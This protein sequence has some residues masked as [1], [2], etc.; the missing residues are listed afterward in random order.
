MNDAKRKAHRKAAKTDEVPDD[1]VATPE[2]G[3]SQQNLWTQFQDRFPNLAAEMEESGP[4][5]RI[6]GVRWQETARAETAV[7]QPAKFAKY[8][9]D[10]VDFLRRC[11]TEEE[12]L[13]IITFVERRGQISA[14]YANA[15]RHQLRGRGVRIFGPKKIWGHYE[16]EG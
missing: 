7:Q 2:A 10:V 5:V 9:P 4:T 13:E 6:D 14:E 8:E 1:E 15:L 3:S 12:A 16:R 11:G